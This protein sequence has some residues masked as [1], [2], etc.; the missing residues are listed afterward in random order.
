MVYRYGLANHLLVVPDEHALSR[1]L[2]QAATREV[3]EHVA[4]VDVYVAQCSRCYDFESHVD[5][6]TTVLL[7]VVKLAVCVAHWVDVTPILFEADAVGSLLL[8]G[9][10]RGERGLVAVA[11]G[12]LFAYAVPAALV[13]VGAVVVERV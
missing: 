11:T 7:E 2:V 1:S 12:N 9:L 5:D 13:A 6:L 3:V 4:L 8:G 10:E